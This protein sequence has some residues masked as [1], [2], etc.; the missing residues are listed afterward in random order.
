ML[1]EK[2]R[3]LYDLFIRV[4]RRHSVWVVGFSGGKDS[5][6][7]LHLVT[8]YLCGAVERGDPVPRRVVVVYND[9]LVELPPV[10]EWASA[11]LTSWHEFVKRRIG[12]VEAEYVV[13]KPRI[14]DVFY[15]RVFARG[16]PAPN[17]KFRWCT[18]L[19]KIQ[20]AKRFFEEF[21]WLLP[22]GEKAA[23][24]VGSRDDESVARLRSNRSRAL[25]VS[26]PVGRCFEAFL[27]RTDYPRVVKYAP[28]RFWSENEVWMF[29]RSVTPPWDGNGAGYS[30]LLR[31]Y[32]FDPVHGFRLVVDSA[33][34]RRRRSVGTRPRHGCWM[35]TVTRHHPGFKLLLKLYESSDYGYYRA[36]SVLWELREVYRIVTDDEG[37]RLRKKSGHLGPLSLEA[38][39]LLY[40]L[41]EL[42]AGTGYGRR[43][44]YGLFE[45]LSVPNGGKSDVYYF[46]YR[47]AAR[48]PREAYREIMSIEKSYSL[49]ASL[50]LS[51]F[52]PIALEQW[53]SHE[54]ERALKRVQ[55]SMRSLLLR[56]RLEEKVGKIIELVEELS[57]R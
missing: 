51:E 5:T 20:P 39:G 6:L 55:G 35:C 40:K 43:V 45:E 44:L 16:Y 50:G 14:I 1:G 23:L 56:R 37:L 9:T 18:E 34:P 10:H 8:E 27:L 21:R 54:L 12:S 13:T 4:A 22:A 11:V 49:R 52:S 36:L 26:C 31:L 28:L 24:L 42:V 33:K 25:A 15:W 48:D 7:L 3:V 53:V 38:R 46:F 29:I 41:I 19:F 47:L 32:G 17:F 57:A 30:S 2:L